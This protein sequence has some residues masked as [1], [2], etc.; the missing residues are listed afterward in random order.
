MLFSSY[1]YLLLFLPLAALG[2]AALQRLDRP[3]AA[4]VWLLLGSIVFYSYAGLSHLPLLLASIVFNWAVARGIGAQR[5]PRARKALL[6]AGIV[7]NLALLGCFKYVNFFL[8]GI[9]GLQVA[10]P[11]WQLPL[12]LSFFTLSQVMG[13]VDCYQEL[14]A[15][16][17]LL[18]HASSVAFFPYVSSGPIVRASEIA[19]QFMRFEGVE[20]RSLLAQRGIY[21][22]VLGLAKKVILADAFGHAADIGYAS[23]DHLSMLEGWAFSLAYTFEIYFDFSGYSDM[24]IGSALLL[25]VRIPQNFNGPFFAKSISEFWQRWHMSLTHFITNYL[26]TPILRSFGKATVRTSALATVLA[27]MIAGLWHGAAWTYIVWGTM[28]GVALAINQLWRRSKR[29]LPRGLGWLLTFLF[30]NA[31]MVVFRSPDLP[32][33]GRMFAAMLPHAHNLDWTVLATAVPVGPGLI[34]QLCVPIVLVQ[35]IQYRLGRLDLRLP[36]MP[37][38]GRAVAYSL[39]LYCIVFHGAAPKAFVYFQF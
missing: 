3:R 13:L 28:H 22:L 39:L 14:S 33:A 27:M 15:P 18:D 12:G 4:Q 19:P 29:K 37:A 7:A 31:A 21:F 8:N 32:T 25:G 6:W 23:V 9:L 20:S 17:S 26:Y 16:L 10:L 30:V 35:L 2:N 36:W 1:T 38:L 5:D 34:M 11:N 24:A